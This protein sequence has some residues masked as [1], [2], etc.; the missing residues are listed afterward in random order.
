[1]YPVI[2]VCVRIHFI[3]SEIYA[4]ARKHPLAVD[5][6][7]GFDGGVDGSRVQ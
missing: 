6:E 1:M 3:L 5:I 2:C 7:A 4:V